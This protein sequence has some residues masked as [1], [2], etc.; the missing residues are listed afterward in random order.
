MASIY[1]QPSQMF[2]LDSSIAEGVIDDA[3]VLMKCLKYQ[4]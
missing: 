1:L 3:T 2:G 4:H